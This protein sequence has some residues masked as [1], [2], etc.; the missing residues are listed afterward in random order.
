MS[1]RYVDNTKLFLNILVMYIKYYQ[2]QNNNKFRNT[3]NV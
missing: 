1:D 2:L 3:I